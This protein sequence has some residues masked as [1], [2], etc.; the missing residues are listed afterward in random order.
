MY[1]R[2]SQDPRNFEGVF[3]RQLSLA[4]DLRKGAAE[5]DRAQVEAKALYG[6]TKALD[7]DIRARLFEHRERVYGESRKALPDARER[8]GAARLPDKR[9]RKK[10][11]DSAGVSGAE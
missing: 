8:S 6:A 11:A 3:T 4:D 10:G 2:I 5:V 7:V 1:D 9:S